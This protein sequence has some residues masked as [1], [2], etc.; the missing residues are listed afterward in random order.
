MQADIAVCGMAVMGR[1]LALNIADHGY[2]VAVFNRTVDKTREFAASPE[3]AEKKI[4]PC[5]SLA[6]MVGRLKKP[7]AIILMIQAGQPVDDQIAQLTPLLAPGD[8]IMD[9]GNSFFLD[10]RR[11]AAALAER[12]IHFLGVGISGG[13]EGARNGPAIMPGG[14][15]D[16]Y[17]AV[18]PILTAIAASVDGVPCCDYIGSDGAGHYVKMVHN[19]IEYADMQLIG[20]AYFLLKH[21][22]GL[23]HDAMAAVFAEWNEGELS[24]YLIEI[25]A[26]IMRRRD[27]EGDGPLLEK[28]LDAAGQKGTGTWTS[29]SALGLGVPAPTIA[30]AVFARSL[31]ARKAERVRAAAILPGPAPAVVANPAM[32]VAAVGQA[33]YASKLCCYA[34]GFALLAEAAREYGWDL[35]FGQ[36][37]MLW[38]GGCIIRARFLSRITA[39]YDRD[40]GLENLLLD[41]YFVDAMARAQDGWRRVVTLAAEH[42]LPVPAFASALAY[43]DGCRTGTLWANLIQAQR[44]YFGAHTYRRLDREGVYHTN[45]LE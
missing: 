21:L 34:Q 26:A 44:D 42:G 19:G 28:I 38:R 1:N 25:T 40:P 3:A 31:S 29:Q 14:D 5:H 43:Y 41:P 36:I 27:P 13:E 35:R 11:R 23:D 39:A 12:G 2:T 8:I 15:S 45:W 30:E 9:G 33:L 37:A 4:I 18:A 22:A 32:V 16:G 24:S 6:D 20:E 7:A 17:R 10:T